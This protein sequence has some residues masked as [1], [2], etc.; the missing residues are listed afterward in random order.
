[1][2]QT[3]FLYSKEK[4]HSGWGIASFIISMIGT[5]LFFCMMYF[6]FFGDDSKFRNLMIVL[7]LL[8]SIGL[9]FIGIGLGITGLLQK[10]KKRV[11][12]I[13]GM[14][15]PVGTILYFLFQSI[16][17]ETIGCVYR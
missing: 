16:A 14:A 2:E 8:G 5:L 10:N 4:E 9:D 11:F 6:L 13:W 17:G 3:N 12:A 1:M 7:T 15:L